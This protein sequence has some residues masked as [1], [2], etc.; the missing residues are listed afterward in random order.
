MEILV[1]P[2]ESTAYGK[3]NV[4]VRGI[5]DAAVMVRHDEAFCWWKN[6]KVDPAGA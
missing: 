3:G 2:Y 4:S 5:V 6:V 1:N